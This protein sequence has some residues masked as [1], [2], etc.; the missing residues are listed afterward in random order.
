MAVQ[1][2]N[3]WGAKAGRH[4]I[5][6][7]VLGVS[8]VLLLANL[9][10][11]YL[12][13]DEAQTALVS[14]TI[15]T[16]GVP[17]GY[18]G[19]NF[20]SQELGAEYGE[21]YIWRWHTWLPFYVV[22]GFYKV[23]GIS[24]F[25]SRL[26]FVL[27]GLLTVVMTYVLAR[28]MGFGS[29]IP[30][31]SAGL[32]AVCVPFMLLC[33][34]CRYYSMS[35]FFTAFSLYAY[36][37][38]LNGRKFAAV[39]LFIASTLLL[40]TQH[41]YIT[42]LFPAILLHVVIF[43]RDRLKIILLVM[44]VV[45]LVNG[46]WLVWLSGAKYSESYSYRMLGSGMMW[47]FVVVLL[48]T[49]LKYVFPFWLFGIV[50][51]SV[52]VRRIRKGQFFSRDKVFRGNLSLLFIFII[53]NVVVIGATAP[54][55]YFRYI[56]PSVPLLIVLAAVVIDAAAEVHFLA[57]V[58]VVVLLLATGQIRDYF[59]EI[60]HDINGPVKCIVSYLNEHSSP[61]DSVVMPYGDMPVK[62]YTNMRV[63]GLLTGEDLKPVEN[64]RWIIIR[65]SP[66]PRDSMKYLFETLQQGRY[67]KTEL[68]CYDTIW[69]N[70]EEPG[71]HRFRGLLNGS[72][73]L[74]FEKTE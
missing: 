46:P 31:I 44:A 72:S 12:W 26:P 53:L 14:R 63:I 41:I 17:R 58:I 30:L 60:T 7:V 52:V 65:K 19:K 55:G 15:L 33:R 20:F 5:L 3:G 23:F 34:Q 39:M 24:T 1:M 16:D 67:K 40:Q 73:I 66:V 50:L 29:R 37:A 68:G 43:R 70:R 74:V 61:G 21:N 42:V 10:N 59:Y 11:Q 4:I 54:Q 6:L 38:I 62:F 2:K 45:T 35:M 57:G 56:A 22:A 36:M 71:L 25:V 48:G 18:D 64:A 9:S 8:L 49:I 47:E 28:E 13:E 32:L 51:V 27:F 69:E